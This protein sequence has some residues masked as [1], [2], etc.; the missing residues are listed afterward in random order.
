MSSKKNAFP[1]IVGGLVIAGSADAAG[2]I[3]S[4]D[5]ETDVIATDQLADDLALDQDI[6]HLFTGDLALDPAVD[7]DHLRADESFLIEVDDPDAVE[8]ELAQTWG[9]GTGNDGIMAPRP[10]SRIRLEAP[11][12]RPNI[13]TPRTTAPAEPRVNRKGKK[14]RRQKPNRT[15][16]R[17][18]K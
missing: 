17:Q 10:G 14:I 18:R 9:G 16:R 6:A 3:R 5:V 15:L 1:L 13:S 4:P 2:E 7:A 11:S 8:I 12:T